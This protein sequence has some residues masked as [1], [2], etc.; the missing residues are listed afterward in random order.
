MAHSEDNLFGS[1]MYRYFPFWPLFVLL[2][3]VSMAGAWA[4][5]NI[6]ALPMYEVSASLLI[7]DERKGVNDSKMTESIDAFTSNKIVEN[8]INV[9]HSNALMSQVVDKLKLYAPVFEEDEFKAIP[10]YSTSPI[11]V[12]LR[13]P[14]EAKEHLKVY[15]T[16]NK[17]KKRVFIEGKEYKLNKWLKTPYGELSFSKNKNKSASSDNP[18][19]FSILD[20]KVVTNQ[21][22]DEVTIEASSKL[23]TVVDLRIK[24][25]VPKRGEDILN[26]LIKTYTQV[27]ISER[28]KLAA[29]TLDF[30]ENRIKLVESELEDL[31]NK[32]VEYKSSNSAVDL[33]EQ[34]RIFLKSVGDNDRKIAEINSQLAVLDKVEKYVVSKNKTAGIVPSTLGINDPV[35]LQLLQKLYD[36]E[37]RHQKLRKTTA[38]NNPMLVSITDEVESIRPSLLENINNQRVN[39][40][41][42]RSNLTATSNFYTVAL[43]NIPQKER[44]LF[45]LNRQQA[46]KNDAYGF[47]L[48]K[49]EE[50]VLSY[51]PS[52]GDVRIVDMAEASVMPAFPK[53]LYIYLIALVLSC[54]T[55]FIFI[56][57]K[58]LMNSKL[59][60]RSEITEYCKLPIAAELSFVK[61]DK[62]KLFGPPSETSVIEQFRQLR[63]TLGLYGR[64]FSKKKIMVTS[65]IPGE[66][67]SYV[68]TNLAYSL[69]SSGKKVILLDFDMRNP[70]TSL[71]FDLYKQRGLIDF[72]S[73]EIKAADIVTQ[74]SF[75]NLYMIPAGTNVGDHTELL[76]NGKLN[77]LFGYLEQHFD[78]IVVDTAPIELVSDAYLLSEYC[79]MTLLV[80]RHAYTPKNLVQRLSQGNRIN[81]IPNVAIVFNG[82]KPRG[83]V[84]GQYGYGYGFDNDGR[85]NDKTYKSRNL[86]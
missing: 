76:L 54:A 30:V 11:T 73:T 68:S 17:D 71:Q 86:A 21:L 69:S 5:I 51:A 74:T 10:A 25:Y 28:N 32:V 81:S 78:Y 62:D 48:Q 2:L 75:E 82:V 13:K 52:A 14:E 63:A 66:G 22:L 12:K 64:T 42:S 50:T 27:A 44:E 36:S 15:F 31:E 33:S 26:T 58:E 53:P 72:L 80:L 18:F 4:Y 41:A 38:E 3:A 16:Y 65:N 37:I 67:K 9:I 59:L 40:L 77:Q 39:L 60:F 57:S 34:S 84:K 6:Y 56:V 45:E 49:R 55:G 61:Q 29:N 47:L 23:S 24:D 7:K 1:L 35:L 43:Q 19:Y 85:Y 83:F 8:E 70:R 20:T 46:I 79:D